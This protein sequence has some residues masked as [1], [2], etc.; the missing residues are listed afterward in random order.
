MIFD[1]IEWDDANLRARDSA[2]KFSR[3]RAG[4][5]ERSAHLPAPVKMRAMSRSKA[6]GEAKLAR[7]YQDSRDLA[8]F[9]T[10]GE[11]VE[12]RRNV[13]ISVRFSDQEIALLH[14][15]AE[16][17]GIKVIRAAALEHGTPLDKQA[18]LAALREA[19]DDVARVERLLG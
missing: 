12:V 4:D 5:L 14:A 3:D 2:S 13:T 8:G 10:E 17:A 11:P 1:R 9:E 18:L 16:Q 7:K 15:K 6:P 19:S